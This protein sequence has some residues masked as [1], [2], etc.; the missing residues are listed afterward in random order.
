MLAPPNRATTDTLPV[1]FDHFLTA[2]SS[3]TSSSEP[4]R[5]SQLKDYRVL[6]TEA[7][8][9][10][11]DFTALA[12]EWLGVPIALISLIDEER[13]WFKSRVGLEV[14]ETARE[15]AFCDHAIRQTDLFVVEDASTDPRFWDNPLVTGEPGIRFYAGCPLITPDGSALGTLCVIDRQ[16]RR[17]TPAEASVLKRLGRQLMHVFEARRLRFVEQAA[18]DEL[19][20]RH[21]ERQRLAMAVERTTNVVMMADPDGRVTWVNPA[22]ERVTGYTL[23]DIRGRTPDEVLQCD[24]SS[25]EARAE[26]RAAREAGRSA[27]VEIL[28]QGKNGRRYWM[29]VD[30]QPQRAPDGTLLGFVATETEITDIVQ[31]REQLHLLLE[32][33]PQG[34]LTFSRQGSLIYA[35]PVARRML[36]WTAHSLD[37]PVPPAVMDRVRQ[38]LQEGA[39]WPQELL[40]VDLGQGRLRWFDT[41]VTPLPQRPDLPEG[42]GSEDGVIVALSDETERV[43][44]GRYIDVA[45]ATLDIG[46]WTWHLQDDVVEVS[47]AWAQRMGLPSAVTSTAQLVHPDDQAHSRHGVVEVLKG[48]KPTFQFEER[49]RQG[50]DSW[51]WMLCG[52][53]V[54][55]RDDQGR[56]VRLSGI[57]ID[58]EDRKRLEHELQRAA[59]TD[60]LTGLPNRRVLEDRLGQAMA[61]AREHRRG[62]ALL[63][64]D[65]DHFKRVN[66][67]YGHAVGDELLIHLTARL[68]GQLNAEQTLARMG[69]DELLVLLP[70][71]AEGLCETGTQALEVAHRLL[72]ALESPFVL[73][74]LSLTMGASVG[75]SVFP[76]SGDE[77]PDD[78]I[79]EADTAMYGV[80]A[81]SRGQARVFEASMRHT[82]SS[83]LQLEM[84]LRQ[85]VA[86]DQFDLY[87]QGKWSAAG[88]PV[89]AEALIRWRHP[90]QG[91]V[92]PAVFIPAA[93][94]S[95][96]MVPLGRWVLRE[97][98]RIARTC[99]INDPDFVVSVNV[100]PRQFQHPSFPDDLRQVIRDNGLP[101]EALMIE[102]TEGVLLQ[103]QLGELIAELNQEGFRFS[104]DD[105]GTGYSSLAYL[106]RV[107][108]HEL[109]IDRAFVRD[110]ETDIS[111][112]ALVQ[113]ILSIGHRFGIDCVAEGVENETQAQW[114]STNGCSLQQGY[115]YDQPVPWHSFV[116]RFLSVPEPAAG[117]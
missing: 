57:H 108:V 59:T 23:D 39:P 18:R 63:L 51:R 96:L 53:T 9:D 114:L 81:A 89:G 84:D 13:Q 3:R 33:L 49:L 60:A 75:V 17:L 48:L 71:L 41:A 27:H 83:R 34:V 58:I 85:A 73:N 80:K 8:P 21:A 38:C 93:E 47:A 61:S 19:E 35:N 115:W 22:F 28:N 54:T 30:L 78:L 101:P 16:P 1:Y 24:A 50:T 32:T 103:P 113:A 111:D 92:P 37:Q 52:G 64:L 5:L 76:K 56:V 25:P 87:L 68:R 88:R 12:S 106:K 98:C 72:N 77:T 79:R 94:D 45:N 74:G 117:G 70:E 82:V 36:A 2:L 66:D 40:S 44:A 11:D 14:R 29:N 67:S 65:L 42:I 4:H 109:K 91:L 15:I 102:I 107:P 104:L 105:F 10:F 116:D 6:D 110:L 55:Q 7:E 46:Y 26:L 86:L 90:Q 112:A 62:G 100:S 20:R 97:G 69:G 95:D 31:Q 43:E 99:R